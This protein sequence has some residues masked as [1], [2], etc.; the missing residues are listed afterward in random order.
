VRLTEALDL[1]RPANRGASRPGGRRLAACHTIE[2]LRVAAGRRLPAA[3]LDYVEGGADDEVTLAQNRAE[4]RTWDLQP[5][6]LHDVAD[7]DLSTRLVD[8]VMPLPLGLAP[9]GYSLLAPGRGAASRTA[10]PTWPPPR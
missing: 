10:S 5:R 1:V 2:Q 8:R 4:L 6:V 9:T 7:V 3:V